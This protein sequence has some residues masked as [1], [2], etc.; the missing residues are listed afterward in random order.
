MATII[1]NNKWLGNITPRLNIHIYNSL[2]LY[3]KSFKL[4]QN[5]S[6]NDIRHI[7]HVL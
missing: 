4:R 3:H 6:L 1:Y 5:I 7:K 2:M